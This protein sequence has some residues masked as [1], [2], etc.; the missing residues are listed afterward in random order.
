MTEKKPGIELKPCPWCGGEAKLHWC[1]GKKDSYVR[2]NNDNCPVPDRCSTRSCPTEEIA[3]KAW[4]HRATDEQHAKELEEAFNAGRENAGF[5]CSW[6][7][8]TQ[9]DGQEHVDFKYRDFNDYKKQ[10]GE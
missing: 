5:K 8:C 1:I 9:A 7:E 6:G 3:I 2:C 4:N 10:R